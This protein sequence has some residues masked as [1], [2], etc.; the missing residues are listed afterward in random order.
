MTNDKHYLTS[1]AIKIVRIKQ[2]R[3]NKTY[4]DNHNDIYD[5]NNISNKDQ[6][7]LRLSN[8]KSDD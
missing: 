8:V 1:Y 3:R 2:R 5:N 6:L 4:N 7:D